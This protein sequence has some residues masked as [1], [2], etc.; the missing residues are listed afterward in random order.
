MRKFREK[1]LAWII[2]GRISRV[3][4]A[5]LATSDIR[6]QSRLLFHP[7][8]HFPSSFA[9]WRREHGAYIIFCLYVVVGS[10][11]PW[12]TRP[13]LARVLPFNERIALA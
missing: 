8:L 9:T 10:F 4:S 6:L 5:T 11:V 2:N 3:A 13:V 1:Q 12:L 7:R